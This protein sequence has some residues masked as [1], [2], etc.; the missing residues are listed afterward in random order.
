MKTGSAGSGPETVIVKALCLI[1]WLY[2]ATI[3]KALPPSCRFYPSCSDYA[4]GSLRKHGIVRGGAKTLF[5]VLRCAPWTRG[6]V[7]LP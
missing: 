4:E 3:S 7:D 6:G 5:R 1:L 2:R